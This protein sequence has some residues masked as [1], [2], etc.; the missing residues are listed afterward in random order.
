VLKFKEKT[1]RRR[2]TLPDVLN[3]PKSIEPLADVPPR[4]IRQSSQLLASVLADEGA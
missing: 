3:I 2:F 4:R 1:M